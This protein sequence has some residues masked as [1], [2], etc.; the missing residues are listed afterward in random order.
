MRKL[1]LALAV[2]CAITGLAAC[3]DK[4]AAPA[5]KPADGAAPAAAGQQ[6]ITIAT[7]NNGDM[8][9]MQKLSPQFEAAN[10][11]IKLNWVVLEEG[12]LRQ[13]VTT[14]IATK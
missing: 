5:A 11:G 7:V 6:T 14:D 13:K 10:P 4:A 12:A 8:V 1:S 3:G 9:E 2:T